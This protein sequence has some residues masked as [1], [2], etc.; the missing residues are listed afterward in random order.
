MANYLLVCTARKATM[1]HC[2]HQGSFSTW[3]YFPFQWNIGLIK[4]RLE[5]SK[6]YLIK[7]TKQHNY[8]ITQ[9]PL[10]ESNSMQLNFFFIEFGRR[11]ALKC[12]VSDCPRTHPERTWIAEIRLWV[13]RKRPWH[14]HWQ[15]TDSELS[16]GVTFFL[17]NAKLT[18]SPHIARE[19][20]Q[21]RTSNVLFASLQAVR[22][23]SM[24][25][26]F[27]PPG[28]LH[29]NMK[30]RKKRVTLFIVKIKFYCQMQSTWVVPIAR[31]LIQMHIWAAKMSGWQAWEWPHF[32]VKYKAHEQSPDCSRARPNEQIKCAVGEQSVNSQWALH[33]S[34]PWAFPVNVNRPLQRRQN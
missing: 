2:R 14:P 19:L 22:K 26:T 3:W 18:I 23:Q 33:L 21:M 11:G 20:V 6:E 25:F 4:L 1:V 8:I 31:D 12:I 17:T 7:E 32:F 10:M 13:T 24:S 15:L 5:W 27:K 9:F 30:R 16:A 34:A 29:I 28:A